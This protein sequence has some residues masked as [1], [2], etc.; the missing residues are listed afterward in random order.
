MAYDVATL[1]QKDPAGLDR[2]VRIVVEFTGNAGEP[3]VR[4]EYYVGPSDTALSIRRWAIDQAANMGSIKTVADAL[5]I[6]QSV[7]LTAIPPATPT[8]KEIWR[9]KVSRYKQ[10]AALGLTGTAATDLAALLAD[11]NATYVTG[12][13]Q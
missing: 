2:R 7:N 5:T 8:A 10:F 3:V 9:G 13:L 12:Y 11:I 4:R 1:V 6:G